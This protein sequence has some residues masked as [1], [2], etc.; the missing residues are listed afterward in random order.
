MQEKTDK[1][2]QN[3]SKLGLT[4]NTAKTQV[5]KIHSKSSNP[6]M[7]NNALEEVEAFTDLG[8]VVD[9]TRGTEA[10]KRPDQQGKDCLTCSGR[11][12]A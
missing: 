11:A 2:S 12:G 5:M 10:N 6:I 9:T 4:P 1:L 7:N 8:S 3:A